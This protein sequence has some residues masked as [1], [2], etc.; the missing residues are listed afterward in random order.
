MSDKDNPT[1]PTLVIKGPEGP[2]PTGAAGPGVRTAQEGLDPTRSADPQGTRREAI[3]PPGEGALHAADVPSQLGLTQTISGD[4]PAHTVAPTRS[5]HA[6]G[7]RAGLVLAGSY[8]LLEPIGEGGMGA[9]Y[10]AEHT[11]TGGKLAVKLIHGR[12]LASPKAAQRFELEARHTAS[13]TH[14]NIVRVFDYGRDLGLLFQVMEYVPGASLEGVLRHH[15]RLPWR[16]VVHIVEQILTALQAAHESERCLIH[17]DIKPGNILLTDHAGH[18]DVV[19]VVDFG[20]S[21]ALADANSLITVGVAGSPATMAPEQWQGQAVSPATDLYGLGCTTYMLL[22]DRAPFVGDLTRLPYFHSTQEP[23]HLGDLAEDDTPDALIQWVAWL[24]RK[25]PLLRP[26]S[27]SQALSVLRS[28]SNDGAESGQAQFRIAQL[29]QLAKQRDP[30]LEITVQLPT[31]RTSFVGRE[32]EL[33]ELDRLHD[34]DNRLITIRG[35]GGLGKSR[36]STEWGRAQAP[37]FPGGVYFCDLAEANTLQGICIHVAQILDVPL[38]KGDA[39]Q[40]IG[41][42]LAGRGEM[43]L[44]LDNFEQIVAL[45]PD[46]VG[47][48]LNMTQRLTLIATSRQALGLAGER[49]LDVQPLSPSGHDSDAVRLFVD[50]ARQVRADFELTPNNREDVTRL[51]AQLDGL[52]LAIELA[53]ARVQAMSPARMVDRLSQR[54]KLLRTKRR[55]ANARQATLKAMLDWSWDLLTPTERAAFTQCA[56]FQGSF[57]LEAAEAVVELD[58][59]DDDPWVIDVLES[60]VDKSLIRIVT[61]G[62]TDEERYAM[63]VS[64][65]EYARARLADTWEPDDIHALRERHLDFM[66][67]YGTSAFLDDIYRDPRVLEELNVELDNLDAALTWA[68]DQG[69]T[70]KAGLCA[71]GMSAY[72]QNKGPYHEGLGRVARALALDPDAAT[73]VRCR[74]LRDEGILARSAGELPRGEEA[75]NAALELAQR[76]NVPRL[77]AQALYHLGFIHR[78]QGR[79]ERALD[80]YNAGLALACDAQLAPIEAQIRYGLGFVLT[81][82]TRWKEAR[83]SFE[84]SLEIARAIRHRLLQGSAHN[85]LAWLLRLRGEFEQARDHYQSSSEVARDINHKLLQSAAL[86]GLADCLHSQGLLEPALAALKECAP[87]ARDIGHKRLQGNALYTLGVVL[88]D[89]AR[90]RQAE[91]SFDECLD[92]ARNL[93]AVALECYALFGLGTM[94]THQGRFEDARK[95]LQHCRQL[96]VDNHYTNIEGESLFALATVDFDQG[97]FED[98]RQGFATCLTLARGSG[99]MLLE[100]NALGSLGASLIHLNSDEEATEMLNEA[101]QLARENRER[102]LQLRVMF[103][104]VHLAHPEHALDLLQ[105]ISA[106]L[107]EAPA[108]LMVLEHDALLAITYLKRGLLEQ[109]RLMLDQASSQLSALGIQPQARLARLIA[110]A[111]HDLSNNT[112]IP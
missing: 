110:S 112:L 86:F 35:I 30:S 33:D 5:A 28:I 48:W 70:N 74:L 2:A 73:H 85:G 25:S 14:P 77:Q 39:V 98:A 6:P 53:A 55:D 37:R 83:D 79:I 82:L 8:R 104:Q 108:P 69:I 56:V 78:E 11:R 66:A 72:F 9:V 105:E 50:R 29:S 62:P 18:R 61:D 46:S 27:A 40:T 89:L 54:F 36:L 88:T 19:K 13:L 12:L 87:L 31:Y 81:D 44:I 52:P 64:V 71:L 42:V 47:V 102:G 57:S 3:V 84:A 90:W 91:S 101:F 93:G 15:G 7:P 109:G 1:Q 45:A 80:C 100:R 99:L 75:L 65:F 59:L 10:L 76:L 103:A 68:L 43:L 26:Q 41:Y 22:A 106:L 34:Q 94:F 60:L 63:F 17:R 20:I 49:V 51:V 24:M 58:D 92:L 32:R 16:R 95:S 97:R 4:L 21:R 38:G 107:Q 96:A 67:A 111:R 23:P